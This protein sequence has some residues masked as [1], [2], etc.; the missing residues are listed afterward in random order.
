LY[1]TGKVNNPHIRR[2]AVSHLWAVNAA[3]GERRLIETGDA[4]QPHG[5][6]RGRRIAYWGVRA[7]RQQRD[8]WSIPA[9]G[10]E[11]VAVTDDEAFDWNPVWSP[12]GR[13]LYFVSDRR[14][15]MS[16]WRVPV[17]EETGRVLGPPEAVTGP[18]AESWNPSFSPDGRRLLYVQRILREGVQHVG[19][20]PERGTVVG[21]PVSITE[22]MR[23]A[24]APTLSP[25]GQWLAVH[26][27]GSAREDISVVR[28]DG[29][30]SRLLTNDAC[31]DRFPQW[32]PDGG[33][34]AFYS[35]CGGSFN[36]WTID[37]AGGERRQITHRRGANCSFP[38]WSPDGGRLAYHCRGLNTFI[39]EVGRTEQAASALPP[40]KEAGRWLV[41][42]SWS[43]DGRKLAGHRAHL[44]DEVPGIFTYSLDSRQ[45]EQIT[46]IGDH[47]VWLSDSRR[48]LFTH[49]LKLYLADSRSK[50]V[51]EVLSLNQL[52][53]NSAAVS[54]DDRR[55]Y[56][57]ALTAEA[58]VRMLTL[59]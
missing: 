28:R 30:E 5:S 46:E 9:G 24:G 41:A 45:Y 48:L 58:D 35:D 57:T 55:I 42:R 21:Q 13:H 6:P 14:G 25:D 29:A 54:R 47:P 20:D 11:P 49:Q 53:V 34:I 19:F 40:M 31:R 56:F 26:S 52:G 50:T 7:G 3:T 16:L 2:T 39:Q 51:R 36:V 43:P 8:I 23:L 18:S 37:T 17:E 38:V 4:L 1:S 44:D 32:S 59:E 27:F 22:G 33:R 10:G 15:V 12:D